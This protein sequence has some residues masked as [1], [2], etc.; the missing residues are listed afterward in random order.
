MSINA[1]QSIRLEQ[2]LSQP[3]RTQQGNGA[4]FAN[5]LQDALKPV[6]DTAAQARAD[7]LSLLTGEASSVHQVVLSAEKAELAL[8]MTLQ[9]RNKVLDAYHEV[10][11]MQV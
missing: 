10:M 9:I 8:R 4:N 11:R 2:A 7:S 3:S 5:L 1:I 6:Q